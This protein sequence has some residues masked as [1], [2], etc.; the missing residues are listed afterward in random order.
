MNERYDAV[1]TFEDFGVPTPSQLR[2][3]ALRALLLANR[4]DSLKRATST[5]GSLVWVRSRFD[6]AVH[7]TMTD[8]YGRVSCLVGRIPSPT[9]AIDDIWHMRYRHLAQTKTDDGTWDGRLTSYT[10][11]W[12]KQTTYTALREVQ[13]VPSLSKDDIDRTWLLN[14]KSEI[15]EYDYTGRPIDTASVVDADPTFAMTDQADGFSYLDIMQTLDRYDTT[16]LLGQ[17]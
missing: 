9:A 4:T 15:P 2:K 6:P 14:V 11:E 12:T 16:Q 17:R 8:E 1:Q 13:D 10:F 3:I 5:S 7:D